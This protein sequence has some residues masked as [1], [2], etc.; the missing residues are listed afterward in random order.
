MQII[1]KRK[2]WFFLSLI[3]LIPGLLS[4]MFQGLN[5]GIDYTGGT[6]LHVS[7]EKNVQDSDLREVLAKSGISN[8]Q[9]QSADRGFIIRTVVLE[10]AE[11][12]KLLGDLE[13]G[14][15]KYDLLRTEKVGPV[16]G[17]EL[18]KAA[19]FSLIIASIFI[20]AY[21]TF[22]FEFKFAIAAISALLHDVFVVIG[23]F[24]MLQIEVDSA[25]VAAILTI[26]GYS[27]NDTIVIF[28][29]I[30]E[31]IGKSKKETLEELLDNSIIQTLTR[32]INTVLTV[33]FV[34]IA[35]Y[36]FGGETTKIFAL[37][38]LV[39]IISGAY[40]SIFTASPILYELKTRFK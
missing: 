34:L 31:N 27:I 17:K 40:S 21:I 13:E 4:F 9:I 28:D 18:R 10:Q 15:G 16:I 24:S 37:A 2:I 33:L 8:P 39:G 22:R 36:L 14:L 32:S 19:V 11:Q 29:R 38:L 26:I 7:F 6:L 20:A 25:F 12:N 1:A 23:I 3:V 30:R 5:Y 35:L